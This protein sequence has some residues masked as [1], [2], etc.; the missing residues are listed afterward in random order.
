MA[1]HLPGLNA[2]R[3]YAAFSVLVGHASN[4]FGEL[5]TR[6]SNYPLLNAVLLDPQSG[7]NLF[8]V[9]SGFLIT[10]LLLREQS[11]AGEIS[12]R[13]F[14][15]R[16]ILRIWPLYY[17]I[18]AI[19][20]VLLPLTIGPAYPLYSISWDKRILLI[21]LLP[22]F[23]SALG[24]IS[25]LWSIGLEEQFYLAWPWVVKNKAN[26]LKITCGV[27]LVKILLTPV[28]AMIGNP[29]MTNLFLTL[30]FESMAIGAVG[31]YLYHHRHPILD[32]AQK[33][34]VKVIVFAGIAYLAVMDVPFSEPVIL[35]SSLAFLLLI[36]YVVTGAKTVRILDT[37][38]LD[39]LGKVSYGIYMAHYPVI[40]VVVYNLHRLNVVEGPTYDAILY[41]TVIAITLGFAF[42]SYYGF[43]RPFLK[44]K[45][46]FTVLPAHHFQGKSIIEETGP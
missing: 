28:I 10:L 35:I 24:P 26:F 39:Q 33:P 31:A 11:T 3:F 4:N 25:H 1:I 41:A 2:I 43:E 17:A 42:A 7:V 27:V 5:R 21:L 6:P 37:P 45:D 30:R 22:N 12:A 34:P 14:Y 18:L 8:F 19:C 29:G 40:Y 46:R 32:F 15:A 44:L 38:V 13:R 20:L 36:I 16:R 23:L 9:L